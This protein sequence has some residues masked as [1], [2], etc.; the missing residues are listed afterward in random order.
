MSCQRTAQQPLPANTIWSSTMAK[1]SPGRT[2]TAA[3]EQHL[4]RAIG[5]PALTL[6][7]V[8]GIIGS[9]WLLGALTA[10]K[11]AGGASLISWILG[12]AIMAVLALVHAEL[13]AAYPVSGGTARFPFLAFGGLGGFTGG[14]MSWLY[15]VTVAPIEAEAS[16]SYLDSH[17][18]GLHFINSSGLLT[19]RGILA[20]AG[21]MLLFCVINAMGVKW[22]S[23]TNAVVV[24]WKIFIPVLAVV[25]LMTTSFHASNFTAGGGFAPF[26]FH[27][28]FAALPLGVIFAEGG[29]EMAIQVG[30][31]AKN[32]QRNIPRAVIFSLIIGALIYLLLEVA[33]VGAL[34]P[35][36]LVHGWAN[37]I[38]GVQ[39]FGPYATLATAAGLGWLVSLLLIDA[40]ISPAGA[41]LVYIG[42]SSRLSYALGRNGYFP[43]AI[44]RISK[45]GVP[46]V[47]IIISFVAGMLFFLPFPSW[48]GL[49][50]LATSA[51]VFMYAMA[52]LAL[53][54][55]RR[56][57]SGRYRPY[58]L[59][60][61]GVL[62]PLAF[63]FA[64]LL[65]YFAGFSTVFWLEV[66]IVLGFIV[67]AI[68]QVRLPKA[69]RTILDI[70]A[71]LWVLPWLAGVLLLSWLGRYNGSPPRVFGVTLLATN[72]L[73]SWWDLAA[74]AAFS[75][76]IY[77][78]AVHST[79]PHLRINAAVEDVET[80]AS[81]E[82][83]KSLV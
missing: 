27:G 37:P 29:F 32:P 20:G 38:G 78:W 24:I 6:I 66:L 69:R 77:Y 45:R 41:G 11:V 57:D 16:L 70:R 83:E 74:I 30:G 65:V 25:A 46:L 79:L 8:G 44:S 4:H 51:M 68:Y 39:G 67:F 43:P 80:E 1:T 63:V 18:T 34:N 35:A 33:F 7:G 47:S 19:G 13:G 56:E 12:A 71:A 5:L 58:R 9:G 60:A 61:A 10:A 49:V 76:V 22:L 72:H 48:S 21:F 59:P 15:N 81:V 2:P 55:L 26:G 73:P 54:G 53:G 52:P 64:N 82:L 17:Y 62:S 14:W 28:I 42:T 23:D 31:E 50:E 36:N 75:L 40:V 3:G